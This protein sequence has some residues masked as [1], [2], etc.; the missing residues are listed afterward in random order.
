M[1][2][3]DMVRAGA[4][5]HRDRVAIRYGD[6]ALTF[7]ETDQAANRLANVLIGAGIEA[8]E[9]VGLL[10]GNG[11]WTVPLDFAC[12][13]ARVCRVPLNTRLSVAEHERMLA[14]AGVRTLVHE[15]RLTERAGELADRMDGLRTLSLGAGRP[16]DL[17]L[18]AEMHR[19]SATDPDLPVRPDDVIL[20]LYTSGTTGRLKAAQHTQASYA[21]IVVNILANLTSPARDDVML[22]A[23]PLIHASGT[24]VLPFWLRGARAAILDGFDPQSYLAAI[25]R[26]GVTH[27]NLV[28]TMLQMLL[29]TG[30]AAA[31]VGTLR[32]VVYGASPMP[33]PVIEEAMAAWGPIFTQ[34]Y[35]QT[36]APLCISVLSPEDHVG[37]DAPL[38]SCGQPGVDVE[39]RLIDEH[40][41]DVVP[42]APGEVAVRAPFT[43]AG[44]L[45]APEL[46]AATFLG[47]GWVRTRDVARFD[48]RG[49]MHLVDRTS[50]MIV[51]GGYNVYP[52]EVED[53]LHSH[54]AVA[55]CAVV[56]A[57]DERW[58]EAVVAFVHRRP[59]AEVTAEELTAHV[60]PRLAGY[61][62]PKRVEFVDA[63]PKS[64]VG[65]I[66]RRALRD[67]LWTG[68]DRGR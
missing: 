26:L 54:P 68:A 14:D 2:T 8:G 52:R 10:L 48:D 11:L 13:K 18:L 1:L 25:P 34:Y 23:A 44:Y 58:V 57:P 67:Q 19:A 33:R 5:R 21:A 4:R 45:N 16:G 24:F 65:K 55:E 50:D 3:V 6:A 15:S 39:L 27:V 32:S 51:S 66:L 59:G 12:L 35:G 47:D 42:G 62:V 22:H 30:G 37:A 49:F 36:E 40:G 41:A 28:P 9:R 46:N 20:A 31:D 53:A 60:R 56:G 61:K 29:A 17:D 64:P 43:M 7:R 38:G 63:I